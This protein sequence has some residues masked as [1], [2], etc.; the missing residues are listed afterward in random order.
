[1]NWEPFYSM[2]HQLDAH[3]ASAHDLE[4][5]NVV[6]H[7]IVALLVEISELANET[8]CFKFWSTKPASEKDVVLEEYVDGLH[9]ILSLGLDLGFRYQTSP[10]NEVTNET[11]A[12]L[13]IFTT[14]ENFKRKKDKASYTELFTAFLSLGK[15]LGFQ[16]EELQEAYKRKNEVNFQRQDEGY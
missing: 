14:V 1:M 6:D 13:S 15:I 2:Q 9:F 8:R 5:V 16:E 12:F 11:Q 7:K 10:L 3:I 4:G